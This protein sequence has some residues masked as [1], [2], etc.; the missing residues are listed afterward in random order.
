[1]ADDVEAVK[2]DIE[3]TREQLQETVDQLTDR[4]DPRVRA[5]EGVTAAKQNPVPVAA[6]AASVVAVVAGIALWRRRKR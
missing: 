3:Q 6:V 2:A 4:L 5:R 1:M